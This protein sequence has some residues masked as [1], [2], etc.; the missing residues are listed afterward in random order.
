M[1]G[2]ERI[3]LNNASEKAIARPIMRALFLGACIDSLG[4]C[5]LTFLSA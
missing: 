1:Y 4:V 3:R 5:L 2:S